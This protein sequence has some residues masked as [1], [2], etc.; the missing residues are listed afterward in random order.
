MSGWNGPIGPVTMESNH[1]SV[2]VFDTLFEAIQKKIYGQFVE[3]FDEPV[4]ADDRARYFGDLYILRDECGVVI[5]LW[6]IAQ[7]A[8][9]YTPPVRPW[10]RSLYDPEAHFRNGPVSFTG[11]RRW[12]RIF[13]RVGTRGEIRDLVGLEAEMEDHEEFPVKV[14]IRR[15]RRNLPTAWDDLTIRGKGRGWKH[16]RRTQW[17]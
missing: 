1:G 5:P 13:R 12:G 6:R 2:W 10:R 9:G 11:K 14:K 4:H 16:H 15:R 17:K 8:Q 7:E 3:S